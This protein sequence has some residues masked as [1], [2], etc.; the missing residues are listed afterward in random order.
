MC[1]QRGGLITWGCGA[2][3]GTPGEGQQEG[4]PG[5]LACLDLGSSR[6][7]TFVAE[8]GV[9]SLG[10]SPLGAQESPDARRGPHP[11]PYGNLV[12]GLS[13]VSLPSCADTLPHTSSVQTG[14]GSKG[15]GQGCFCKRGEDCSPRSLM[16]CQD[17]VWVLC[18]VEGTLAGGEGTSGPHSADI[19]PGPSPGI[20]QTPF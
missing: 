12:P 10:S 4:A 3:A 5:I 9:W 7:G 2:G 14:T 16:A 11:S 13:P 18:T 20:S 17:L 1:C 6:W 15:R 19:S 8:T